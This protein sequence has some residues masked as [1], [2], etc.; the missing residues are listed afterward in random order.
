MISLLLFQ[1]Q[2][3]PHKNYIYIY[4]HIV[5]QTS[6]IMSDTNPWKSGTSNNS[7]ISGLKTS[8]LADILTQFD[9]RR[10]DSA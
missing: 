3:C 1:I 9:R 4:I 8:Q 5:C 2:I 6:E 7:N 10:V